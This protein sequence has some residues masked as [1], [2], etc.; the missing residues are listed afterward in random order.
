MTTNNNNMVLDFNFVSSSLV[1]IIN[2]NEESCKTLQEFITK[3]ARLIIQSYTNKDGYPMFKIEAI[4]PNTTN[5]FYVPA[6]KEITE[7]VYNYLRTGKPQEIVFNE[8]AF[9]SSKSESDF[10]FI[11]FQAEMNLG[12]RINQSLDFRPSTYFKGFTKHKKGQI[13]Y[14]IKRTEVVDAY[15]TEKELI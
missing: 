3:E 5:T 2:R 10:S 15:L 6:Y 12:I 13:H 11:L 1:E 9:E 4:L 14:N 7:K 8:E